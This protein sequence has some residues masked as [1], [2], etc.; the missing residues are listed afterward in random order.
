MLV[1][2]AMAMRRLSGRRIGALVAGL[3]ALAIAGPVAAASPLV[4]EGTFH[5]EGPFL[6]C[7]GFTAIGSWEIHRKIT[8][9]VDGTGLPVADH[10][11]VD[12]RGRIYNPA[13]G[14]SVPDRG[15]RSFRDELAPDGSFLSTI[16]TFERTNPYVHEA[17]QWRLGP[18][19]ANGDQPLLRQVGKEGFT[20]ANIAALCAALE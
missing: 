1:E 10:V 9:L 19:D 6:D 18:S 16:F 3:L 13:N 2:G 12:F 8:T 4:E 20:D 17:G 14:A 7:P 15:L 11:H 5:R